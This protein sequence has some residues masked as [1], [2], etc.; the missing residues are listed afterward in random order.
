M[1]YYLLTVFFLL[2]ILRG[3]SQVTLSL[4]SRD[5]RAVVNPDSFEVKGRMTIKNTS[6]QT[7][8]FTWQR[9]VSNLTTG[10]YCLVCEKNQCW[11]AATPSPLDYIELAP[12]AS[13]NLDIFVRPDKKAG[14]ALVDIKVFEIGNE[15]NVVT[16][17]YTFA[18]T[19]KAKD[20]KVIEGADINI[21]PNPAVDFFMIPENSG[22]EKIV[23]YNIIGRQMRSFKAVDGNKYY[24][25]DLPEGI[26]IIRLLNT[27]GATVKT[28]RLSKNRIKA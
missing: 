23:I 17:K 6:T 28:A 1:K 18:T 11:A 3:E 20:L 16:G 22:V 5:F 12:G 13:S 2:M 7:K 24:I 10:W 19:T 27:N 15:A 25:N 9:Y 4:S 14:S 21:Y 26:Y 8:K